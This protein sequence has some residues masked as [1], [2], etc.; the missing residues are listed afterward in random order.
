MLNNILIY[1]T[2]PHVDAWNFKPRHAEQI[3]KALPGLEVVVCQKSKEF[4]RRLPEA[5]GAVVWYF[6]R[7]WL[8]SAPRLRLI[9]TPAA[10]KDWVE[11]EPTRSL[12][13]LFGSFHG[14]MIAESVAGAIFYFCKAFHLSREMQTQRWWEREKISQN[15]SSLSGARVTILGFGHIGREI[16]RALKPF[17]CSITGIKRIETA[18]PDYFTRGDRVVAADRM[19]EVLGST[20]HLVM[21]LPGGTATDGMFKLEHFQALPRR[22]YLYN[23]GRGNVYREEDLAFALESRLI[24]GAYLDV[25]AREPLPESSP[26]WSME[27]TLIQ[28]HLSAAS[29]RYLDLFVDELTAKIGTQPA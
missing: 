22:C 20:D 15:M 21:A 19:A 27:N 4:L 1:L 5:E 13:I 11:A 12:E 8:D 18:P 23:V 7:Q 26:L 28:P 17:G 2:H 25:F 10:G 24:A 6:K 16:G 29:P 9:A 14:P 3:R